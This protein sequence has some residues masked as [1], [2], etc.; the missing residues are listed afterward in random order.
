M[1]HRP[2]GIAGKQIVQMWSIIQLK[3]AA[4]LLARALSLSLVHDI[5]LVHETWTG[6]VIIGHMKE[7]E[8]L[9]IK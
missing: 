8:S 1:K 2:S 7:R 5:W 9:S 6:D 3:I 4:G